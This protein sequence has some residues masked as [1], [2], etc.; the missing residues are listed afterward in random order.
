MCAKS[1]RDDV[2]R[3]F[4]SIDSAW[5]AVR[6]ALKAG[7]MTEAAKRAAAA[8]AQ[9]PLLVKANAE[10][11][12][13][14]GK[15]VALDDDD[16][17]WSDEEEVVALNV[18][19]DTLA[20][21]MDEAA[22][23]LESQA[24]LWSE[25]A[26]ELESAALETDKEKGRRQEEHKISS[27]IEEDGERYLDRLPEWEAVIG[28]AADAADAYQSLERA[29]NKSAEL[30]EEVNVERERADEARSEAAQ[31][32]RSAA[33][34]RRLVAMREVESEAR[35]NAD[36]TIAKARRRVTAATLADDDDSLSEDRA[37]ELLERFADLVGSDAVRRLCAERDK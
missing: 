1:P 21:V 33:A 32:R 3:A 17:L 10:I 16:L 13:D 15:I 35:R 29:E 7:E 6:G 5:R 34:G 25:Q 4:K 22:D 27:V 11:Y 28:Q 2:S 20:R 37:T 24:H 14:T 8:V 26:N 18:D 9:Q 19:A 12:K 30:W 31:K 36:A 23:R